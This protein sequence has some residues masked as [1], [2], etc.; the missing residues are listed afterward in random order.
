MYIL[1][2]FRYILNYLDRNNI[3]AA[4]LAGLEQDLQLVGSQYQS[5]GKRK[6]NL[7]PFYAVADSVEYS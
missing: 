4:R 3:A 7:T 2:P 1:F 5:A 6:C